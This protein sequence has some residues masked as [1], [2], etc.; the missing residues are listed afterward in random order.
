M[1]N[2]RR[3]KERK[4]VA[5]SMV[6]VLDIWVFARTGKAL[7]VNNNNVYVKNGTS[8]DSLVEPKE[9]IEMLLVSGL[10]RR[11]YLI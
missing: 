2:E 3:I 4:V 8:V 7:Q 9:R 10:S 11:T 5:I 6:R 1:Q